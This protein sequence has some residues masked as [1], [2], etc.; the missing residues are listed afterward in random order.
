ME[1]GFDS[2]WVFVPE[3][4]TESPEWNLTITD[5]TKRKYDVIAL[6]L[7]LTPSPALWFYC[8][9]LAPAPHCLVGMVG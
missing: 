5:D 9:Q 6:K 4:N 8:K 3:G 7:I 1:G 2:G